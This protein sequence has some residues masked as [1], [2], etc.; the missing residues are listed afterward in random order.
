MVESF[1]SPLEMS[2]FFEQEL[3]EQKRI[4][5]EE[6]TL[7]YYLRTSHLP[8]SLNELAVNLHSV[9]SLVEELKGRG[10]RYRI[11]ENGFVIDL[12]MKP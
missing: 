7:V 1:T 12:D 3:I 10:V 5:L 6:A 2:R 11:V 4:Q 9:A 8:E